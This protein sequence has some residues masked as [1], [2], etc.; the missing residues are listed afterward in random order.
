MTPE[1]RQRAFIATAIAAILVSY[2]VLARYVPGSMAYSDFRAALAAGKITEVTV[3][4]R[5]IRTRVGGV[6]EAVVRVDDP[7]LYRDLAQRHVKITG[8]IESAGWG[9]AVGW[10]VGGLVAWL[11]LGSLMRRTVGRQSD[12]LGVGRSKAKVFVEKDVKVRFEDVAGVDEAKEEL[13]EVIEFLRSPE[14]FRRLGARIPKGVLLVGP[15]GTGKTLLA[16]AVAGEADAL[17]RRAPGDS[18]PAIRGRKRGRMMVQI[19]R[20]AS[21]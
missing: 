2:F 8:E 3:A 18:R 19:E 4:P 14:R 17:G 21:P 5:W 16:R 20:V 9:S 6:D 10:I 1:R 13:K 7:D 12:L 15:P 11:V